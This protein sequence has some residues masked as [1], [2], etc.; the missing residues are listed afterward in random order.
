MHNINEEYRIVSEEMDKVNNQLYVLKKDQK[1][2]KYIEL[3][4]RNKEL[5]YKQLVL[6]RQTKYEEYKNCHHIYV[7]SQIKNDNL[8]GRQSRGYTCIKCGL[9]RP[10]LYS[11]KE[12][13]TYNEQIMYDYLKNNFETNEFDIYT[14]YVCNKDLARAIYCKIKEHNPD[15]DDS[16]VKKYFEIALD[17]IRNIKV[18]YE[19]MKSRAKRLHLSSDFDR[20][21]GV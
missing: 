17:N 16:L 21:N 4:R 8:K 6:Y 12:T 20:W 3:E 2:Q 18:N 9:K 7:T 15:I 13:L 5:R 1:V 10:V 11:D 14:D 19:R